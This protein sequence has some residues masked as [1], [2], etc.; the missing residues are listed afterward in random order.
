M[1]FLL[2]FFYILL[3][4]ILFSPFLYVGFYAEKKNIRLETEQSELFN[5]REVLLENLRDLKTEFDTGKLTESEFRSISAGLI[6]E[7]ENQDKKIEIGAEKKENLPSQSAAKVQKFC[8][9]C[10][11]KI[12]LVGAKFCPECGTK[13]LVP[14]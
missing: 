5:R 4:L 1:D 2:I 3:A 10:G 13:L 12:E 14:A 7:L 11:F 9:N 8:H 6:E